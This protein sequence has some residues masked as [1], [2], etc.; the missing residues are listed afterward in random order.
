MH[1]TPNVSFFVANMQQV[2]VMYS[3]V[4]VLVFVMN[5]SQIKLHCQITTKSS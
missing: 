2:P 1:D 5:A 4:Q 3:T